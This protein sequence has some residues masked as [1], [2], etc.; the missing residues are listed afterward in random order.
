MKGDRRVLEA[1]ARTLAHPAAFIRRMVEDALLELTGQR[2]RKDG[3]PDPA[4]CRAWL[5]AHD[6]EIVFDEK[7]KSFVRKTSAG[8]GKA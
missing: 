5:S 1:A 4:A 6:A 3:S 8:A 7:E 2:F